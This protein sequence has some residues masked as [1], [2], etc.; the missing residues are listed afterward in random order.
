M[1]DNQRFKLVRNASPCKGCSE[2]FTACS[3]NCPKDKRGEYGYNAWKAE[4]EEVN[5]KR[6]AYNDLNRRKSWQ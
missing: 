6:K 5:K 1:K 2:R 4:N 3:D